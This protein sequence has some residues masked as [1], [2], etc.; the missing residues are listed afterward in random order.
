MPDIFYIYIYTLY[1]ENVCRNFVSLTFCFM[2][3]SI[4]LYKIYDLCEC[5]SI[6]LQCVYLAL[7]S[8]SS[9]E[10]FFF[11]FLLSSPICLSIDFWRCNVTAVW[12]IYCYAHKKFNHITVLFVSE[13]MA[14][15]AYGVRLSK[16]A[17]ER[18][19]SLSI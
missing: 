12:G 14:T 5:G 10:F 15:A 4:F 11:V 17:E 19:G 13:A 16:F 9:L 2:Y 7:N 18:D 1:T 8:L 6:H 3:I